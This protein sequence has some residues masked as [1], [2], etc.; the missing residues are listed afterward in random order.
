[1]ERRMQQREG[2]NAR[3]AERERKKTILELQ[4]RGEHIPI[5]LLTAIVDPDIKRKIEAQLN[6]ERD[7]ERDGEKEDTIE[8]DDG[9]IRFDTASEEEEEEEEE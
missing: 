4:K 1:M 5:E 7:R 9:F 8:L 3:R 2:I 6:T